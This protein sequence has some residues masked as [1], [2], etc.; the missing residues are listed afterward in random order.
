MYACTFV[1][2]LWCRYFLLTHSFWEILAFHFGAHCLLCESHIHWTVSMHIIQLPYH[3]VGQPKQKVLHKI[4]FSL[5]HISNRPWIMETI[6][7]LQYALGS[8]SMC[9]VI[10]LFEPQGNNLLIYD[11]DDMSL[12]TANLW[13]V[14]FHSILMA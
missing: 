14:N 6:Q 7:G 2:F 11:M 5:V 3:Y 8:K 1:N 4:P 9:L 12:T 10:H 13:V